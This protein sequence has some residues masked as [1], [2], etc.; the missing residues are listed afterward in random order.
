MKSQKHIDDL[1]KLRIEQIKEH[2]RLMKDFQN[3]HGDLIDREKETVASFIEQN[4]IKSKTAK[5]FLEE[6]E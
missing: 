6:L 5:D 4:E 2:E 1:L 3:K